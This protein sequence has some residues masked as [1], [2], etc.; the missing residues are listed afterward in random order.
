MELIQTEYF[1]QRQENLERICELVYEE[2]DKMFLDVRQYFLRAVEEYNQLEESPYGKDY[3]T[4]II[5]SAYIE[6]LKYISHLQEKNDTQIQ[7]TFKTK[8]FGKIRII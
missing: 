3:Q 6:T 1:K 4:K 2:K 7:T 8:K 5:Q